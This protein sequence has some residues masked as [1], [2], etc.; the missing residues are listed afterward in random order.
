MAFVSSCPD[1]YAGA[2]RSCCGGIGAGRTVFAGAGV[3]FSVFGSALRG[4]RSSSGCPAISS[5]ISAAS[6]DSR[7]SSASAIRTAP[8]GFRQD[9]LRSLVAIEDKLPNFL[10]DRDSRAFAVVAMLRDLASEEDLFFLFAE[11]QRARATTFRTGK[12]SCAPVRSPAR[13]RCRRRSSSCRGT[14]LRPGGRPS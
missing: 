14:V 8:R 12:P 9:R 10:V 4:R 13:Y 11:R 3:G 5:L 7:S 1:A 2:G 6:S